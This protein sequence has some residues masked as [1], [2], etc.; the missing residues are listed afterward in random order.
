MERIDFL[1]ILEACLLYFDG[2][3]Y[4]AIKSNGLKDQNIKRGIKIVVKLKEQS[5]RQGE[6]LV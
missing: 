4:A 6:K 1:E 3:S 5:K 2:L